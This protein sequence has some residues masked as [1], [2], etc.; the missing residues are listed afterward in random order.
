MTDPAADAVAVLAVAAVEG[1]LLLLLLDLEVSH[2]AH[3]QLL[4]TRT[5]LLLLA[6]SDGRGKN[7][8]VCAASA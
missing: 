3:V 2:V 8:D 7:E 5:L 4:H 6:T 1:L